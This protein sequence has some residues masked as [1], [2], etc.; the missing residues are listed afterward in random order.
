MYAYFLFAYKISLAS[1]YATKKIP[2]Q[3][4]E[5]KRT[6]GQIL[7]TTTQHLAFFLLASL[8][9]RKKVNLNSNPT[10]SFHCEHLMLTVVKLEP[11]SN[12]QIDNR[13]QECTFSELDVGCQLEKLSFLHLRKRTSRAVNQKC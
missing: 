6:L 3:G 4:P 10:F 5:K 8:P 2:N 12:K 9:A 11:L 1:P 7:T 13:T